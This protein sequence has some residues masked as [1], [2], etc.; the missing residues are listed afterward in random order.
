VVV[1]GQLLPSKELRPVYDKAV[2][3]YVYRDFSKSPAD[4][5][6][7]RVC[8][9]LG[10]SSYP[11]HFLIDPATLERL[12]DTGREVPGFVAAMNRVHVKPAESLDAAKRLR[13]ADDRAAALEKS[14]SPAAAAKALADPDLLVRIRAVEILAEKEPEG[15]VPRAADL[16][17]TENDGF[18][19]LVCDGLK[20]AAKPECA[21]ALEALLKDPGD[22]LNP[23]VVRIHAAQALATCGDAGSV[24]AL[25][26]WA[27]SGEFLNGLTRIS[28]DALAAVAAR[29]EK[30]RPAVREALAA[31]YP[32]PPADKASM[33]NCLGLARAVHAALEKLTGKKVP[34]PDPYDA[35]ARDKLAK[36]W[37]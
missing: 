16:L 27:S 18:R 25:R 28:V 14:G 9:R 12:A 22:S 21:R 31:S 34:F 20:K 37:K 8:L 2:W 4:L 15:L 3:L 35:A 33:Q 30:A 6:A 29:A 26:P 1:E 24:E 11:Q 5:A 36:A 7:E 19:Y 10:M 23:N 17:K 13:E 32:P